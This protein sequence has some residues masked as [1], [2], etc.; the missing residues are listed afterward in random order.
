M[1]EL[2]ELD[3][4]NLPAGLPV[5]VTGAS[6]SIGK[7]ICR[8]LMRLRVPLIMAC[9]NE[10]RFADTLGEITRDNPDFSASFLEIDLNNSASVI[11]AVNKLKGVTLAGIVNN[12]GT[13]ERHF[14]LSPD[15]PETTMNVNYHDT[16]LLNQLLLTQVA[17]GG[18]VVFTTSLTRRRWG[19]RPLPA[20][21]S[22]KSF[23]Q[24][25][26]Y[27]LSKAWITRF[28]AEF[29]AEGEA[30]GVRVNCADPGIVDS[31]MI[32]MDRWFDPIADVLFRPLIRTPRNGAVPA[33][34]ALFS[35][36]TGK[37]FTLRSSLPLTSDIR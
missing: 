9:R 10:R 12:A 18:C 2:T 22:E 27:S 6:G 3:I 37:I 34:R 4:K 25:T 15:G 35:N 28:A 26:T 5:L 1:K 31:S 33:L 8:A 7:E 20:T 23:G 21:V 16:R 32:R 19:H 29:V 24:L 30:C 11:E 17:D 13:M 14:S 36:E